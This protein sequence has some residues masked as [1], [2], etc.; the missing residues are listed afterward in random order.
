M[1]LIS[2]QII[3]HF[4]FKDSLHALSQI[5]YIHSKKNLDLKKEFKTENYYLTSSARTALYLIIKSFKP[6]KSKSIGIPAFICGV[7][8]TPFLEEGYKIEWIDVDEN[9]LIDIK[10]FEKKSKN[11][12]LVI[13]PHIFGQ[14][15]PLEAVY[16]IANPQNILVVEDT[17][18]LIPH[19]ELKNKPSKQFSENFFDAQ[20]LSFG[21]EKVLSC[22]TGGALILPKKSIYKKSVEK[23]YKNLKLPSKFWIFQ[24]LIQ[25]FIFSISLPWWQF[26][27]KIIPY[28]FRKINFL[29]LAVTPTEKRGREDFPQTKMPYAQQ[30]ILKKQF[31]LLPKRSELRKQNTQLWKDEL[32]KLFPEDCIII[33]ENFFRVLV[34]NKKLETRNNRK[35]F[36][37]KLKG[38]DFHLSE[39]EGNPIAPNVE[40]KKFGY[41]KGQCPM[42]EQFSKNYKTFPT[43]FRVNKS[44]IKYFAKIYK[45]R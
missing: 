21:R 41:I 34:V 10:D 5:F 27:G 37:K 45:S 31:K 9:G 14:Q 44:V 22:V 19:I 18:H 38:T 42:A 16:K 4:S 2:N 6:P 33:P 32:K 26:G 12:G 28:I 20:I 17:A 24:H 36:L 7:V 1:K 3:P 29:P 11:I 8:A 13:V 15:A 43:H 30:K 25:P 23:N 35:Y 40:I 39:W